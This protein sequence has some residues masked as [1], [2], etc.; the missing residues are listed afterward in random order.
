MCPALGAELQATPQECAN[1]D[2]CQRRWCGD[3]SIIADPG[4]LVVA[5][6]LLETKEHPVFRELISGDHVAGNRDSKLTLSLE[7]EAY[8]VLWLAYTV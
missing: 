8:E 3:G 7:L 2:Q 6:E 1:A 5:L 4:E